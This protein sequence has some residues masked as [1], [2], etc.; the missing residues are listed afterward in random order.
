ML[1]ADQRLHAR[2]APVGQVHLGLVV[3]LQLAAVQAAAQVAEQGQPGRGVAVELRRRS[4]RRRC[5]AAWPG[6]WRRRRAACSSSPP[7]ASSWIHGDADA[8]LDDEGHAL[9]PD[10]LGDRGPQ[11]GRHLAGCG[12]LLDRRKQDGELV[13]AEPGH[14]VA[15]ADAVREPV[16]HQP[17]QPVADRV[18]EGVVDLLEPAVEVEQQEPDLGARAAGL[19]E[20]ARPAGG[21][22]SLRLDSPV[23]SSWWAWCSRCTDM[24]ALT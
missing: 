15:G 18:A 19:G 10:R 13:A 17:Q 4:A 6:T 5:G 14:Q 21:I 22:S 16:R 7:A 12:G 9:E 3:Q 1:P 23:S 8:D 24:A 11:P 2:H 20:R